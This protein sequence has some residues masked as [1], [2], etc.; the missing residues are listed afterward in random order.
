MTRRR[1]IADEVSADRAAIVGEHARHLAQVLRAQIGQQFEISTGSEVWQG[2]VIAVE[3]GRVE[4]ELGDL[5]QQSA[6]AD[7]TVAVSIFKFERMEWMI[8]KCTELGVARI[9]PLIA[10]RSEKHLVAAASKRLERWRRIAKQ[11]AEQAR[12]VWAPEV[13]D[14]AKIRDLLAMEV[15]H[16]VLL[17]EIEKG[18]MLGEAISLD[19]SVLMAFGPEGGWKPEEILAFQ[20]A[21]WTAASL[22]ANILRTE[23]AVIA[24]VAVCTSGMKAQIA[25]RNS[26]RFSAT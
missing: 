13:S 9:I 1:W 25:K 11:A 20:E 23:T 15:S 19:G 14:P 17:S 7:I 12:R 18:V 6:P 24:A 26:S 21:G 8:E 3:A 22:G 2:R 16:R 10:A 4:F 5:I